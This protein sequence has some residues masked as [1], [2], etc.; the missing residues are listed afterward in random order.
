M[1]LETRPLSRLSICPC[2]YSVLWDTIPLGTVY[3][4]D[5][6][7]I[8]GGFRYRCGRCGTD[9]WDVTV[10]NASQPFQTG[11]PMAPLP[12]GLFSGTINS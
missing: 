9:Q 1:R 5:L 7:T 2:G 12:F 10:V 6:D 8:R 3:Q 4:I 11:A